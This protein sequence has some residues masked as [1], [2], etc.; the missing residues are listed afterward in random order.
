MTDQ[1]DWYDE[2]KSIHV[3][4]ADGYS[5]HVQDLG[6]G[7][8]RFLNDPLLG[9]N[10]PSWGDRVDLFY[11]PCDPFE[12]PR[13]GYRVYAEGVEPTGRNFGQP[14]K[15]TKSEVREQKQQEKLREK[16]QCERI[17]ANF[18]S[19]FGR[20]MSWKASLRAGRYLIRYSELT[21]FCQERGLEI[22]DDLHKPSP[23]D[24]I[25]DFEENKTVESRRRSLKTM[26]LAVAKSYFD[27]V[28][29]EP[30]K[31]DELVKNYTDSSTT[32]A[33]LEAKV[34]ELLD[35]MDPGK[36]DERLESLCKE[37]EKAE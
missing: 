36:A 20:L 19:M 10:G 8:C 27:D 35:D 5:G 31:V 28:E 29:V 4:Y 32:A 21:T 26:L 12:R 33:I 37:Q 15:P 24:G 22:P 17:S 25:D 3:T 14:K 18:D 7:T 23:F 2:T 9:P 11:N 34:Q 16:E 30:Q 1:P 6:D 13:V